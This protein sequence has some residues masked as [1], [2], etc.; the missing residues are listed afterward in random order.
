MGQTGPQPYQHRDEVVARCV[1]WFT[2][3][4]RPLP[5]REQAVSPW[6]ILVSEV[7]LQQTPTS[8]VA[9]VWQAW[10][11]RWPTPAALAAAPPE[12]VLRAWGRLGYP[13]RALR[14]HAT[15]AALVARHSGIVPATAE[16][17][18]ALPGIGSYTAA[19][20]LAFAYRKRCLVLDVNVR[21]VLA[22]IEGG[23]AHPARAET[24]AERQRGWRYVPDDDELA[25]SWAAASME[26][27]ATLCTAR[28]PRCL[29]CPVAKLC[30]WR[31][32][33]YPL[34]DGPPRAAQPWEGTDRQCRGQIMAALRDSPRPIAVADL[35]WPDEIQLARC[36]D[37]LVADGLAERHSALLALPGPSSAS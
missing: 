33:G 11:Q 9:P 2:T 21:R 4:A 28:A 7:M 29:P 14:L 24:A 34:W 20:V 37:S 26:L 16:E 35:A 8:R 23:V 5:W 13:R 1:S 15:A 17:L 22:R 25:A 19:A 30:T 31:A 36:I 6:G 27:G 10:L 12:A 3:A 32:R 18:L